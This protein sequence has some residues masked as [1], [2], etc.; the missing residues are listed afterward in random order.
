MTDRLL[1]IL[2]ERQELTLFM[3]KAAER[4]VVL[5]REERE[6]LTGKVQIGKAKG[7]RINYPAI[8]SNSALSPKSRTLRQSKY[9]AI[10]QEYIENLEMEAKAER[11]DREN[12][13]TPVFLLFVADLS[14]KTIVE[15]LQ[16]KYPQRFGGKKTESIEYQVRRTEAWKEFKK[17]RQRQYRT[18][19]SKQSTILANPLNREVPLEH[20]VHVVK[21]R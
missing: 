10:V 21:G 16:K 12:T 8:H 19:L 1:E 5:D 6:I 4:L 7:S 18:E 9:E 17:N 3:Q 14:V 2:D 20:G 11:E 15:G 13:E